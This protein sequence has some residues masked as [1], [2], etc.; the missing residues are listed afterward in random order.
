MKFTEKEIKQ[1]ETKGISPEQVKEQL[2][3]FKEGIP[4]VDLRD[5]ATIGHGI[6]K[7]ALEE[8]L[9]FIE[10]FNSRREKLD[11]LKFTPASGAATRMFK[12]LFRFLKEYNPEKESVN[13]YINRN[14]AQDIRLF[15]VGLDSFT[16]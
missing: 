5:P 14:N 3:I 6:Y 2:A 15:F 1:L 13:A 11:L 16:F 4:Y 10:I 7:Y 8:Q 12:F 9:H